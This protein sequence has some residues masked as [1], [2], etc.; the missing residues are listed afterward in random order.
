MNQRFRPDDVFDKFIADNNGM[1][2]MLSKQ[3]FNSWLRTYCLHMTGSNPVEG[4]DGA[5]KWMVFPL[6]EDKQLELI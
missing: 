5:G 2:R 6:K 3:R 1:F 4:R